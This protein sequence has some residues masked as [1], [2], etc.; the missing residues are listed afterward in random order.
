MSAANT[1]DPATEAAPVYAIFGGDAFLRNQAVREAIRAAC[2]GASE[3]AEVVEFDGTQ[4]EPADV[5][6]ACRTMSLLAPVSI[7]CVRDADPFIKQHRDLIERYVASPSSSAVLILVLNAKLPSNTRLY[8][9]IAA[10]GR[11]VSCEPPKGAALSAWAVN[12]AQSA[13][14]ARLESP[15]ARRLVEL[16]G[17]N[18]GRMDSEL[19]KLSTFVYPKTSIRAADVDE[20]VG[21][22]R[23]EKVF[24]ITDAV[25]RRDARS[26]LTLWD[27]VLAGDRQAEYR[28]VG[29]LAWG[30]R[31]L[32]DA[33][34]LV[35]Q[36]VAV[37]EAA[38]R[39]GIWTQPA[40]LQRQLDRFSASQWH[41]H[42]VQLLQI[43]F[44][45]KNG[46]GSIRSGVEKF[47]VSLCE[48]PGPDGDHAT[49][50]PRA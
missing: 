27:Q 39:S 23:E 15:A 44:A 8:K 12:H 9:R 36:G 26:A 47:I 21:V 31:R 30:F 13:Y 35:G 24:G 19:A 37:A 42:L 33:K 18:L 41:Q 22:S 50:R 49:T 1:R 43:D 32:A 6:D 40:S 5:F 28:A 29:G 16:V 3:P 20:M 11:N 45:A 2:G 38:R 14:G 34:R 10:V 4:A 46:L 17:D 7:V 25:A 48:A